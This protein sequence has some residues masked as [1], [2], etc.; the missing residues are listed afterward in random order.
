LNWSVPCL[1]ALI[2]SLLVLADFLWHQDEVATKEL[3]VPAARASAA[4]PASAG[5]ARAPPAPPAPAAAA[6]AA[7]QQ[8]Q[9]SVQLPDDYFAALPSFRDCPASERQ[10]CG[11]DLMMHRILQLQISI[12]SLC[13][14]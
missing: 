4:T 12:T 2:Q 9:C 1:L 11:V 13:L 7:A 14:L 8:L 3:D 6:A 10:V 5:A